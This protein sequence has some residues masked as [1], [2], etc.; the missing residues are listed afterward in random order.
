MV[1][2]ARSLLLAAVVAATP[3]TFAA[4]GDPDPAFG[5]GG[6]VAFN[7]GRSNDVMTATVLQPDG[8]VIAV[9]RSTA[10]QRSTLVLARYLA[11]GAADPTFGDAGLVRTD[12]EAGV[13]IT[14]GTALQ[15]DG[16]L[17]V[18]LGLCPS[19]ARC[20]ARFN[21]NGTLDPAFGTAGRAASGISTGSVASVAIQPDGKIVGTRGGVLAHGAFRVTASG[22]FDPS[23]GGDGIVDAAEPT[24][25]SGLLLQPDGR[26]VL[27]GSTQG[28]NPVFVAYRVNADG[29]T[30][31]SFSASIPGTGNAYASALQWDGR[32]VIAGCTWGSPLA[33]RVVRLLGSG[34]LDASL[35]GSGIATPQF[36]SGMGQPCARS[37]AIRP[38]GKIAIAGSLFLYSFG[39]MTVQLMPDG[40]PDASFGTNGLVSVTTGGTV[41]QAKALVLQPDGRLVVGGTHFQRDFALARVGPDGTHDTSFGPGGVARTEFWGGRSGIIRRV[42]SWGDKTVVFARLDEAPADFMIPLEGDAGIARFLADGSPDPSFGFRGQVTAS[43]NSVELLR[44]SQFGETRRMAVQPDGKVLIAGTGQVVLD[45]GTRVHQGAT[46]ARLN[47]D[48]SVDASFGTGGWSAVIEGPRGAEFGVLA[49]DL[50]PDGRILAAGRSFANGTAI[51]FLGRLTPSGALDSSFGTAGLVSIPIDGD[52]SN[53]GD[54]SIGLEPDGRILLSGFEPKRVSVRRFLANGS[55][56]PSFASGGAYEASSGI[57]KTARGVH[58]HSDGR[59]LLAGHT[60]NPQPP[61]PNCDPYVGMMARTNSAGIVDGATL[62]GG[63]MVASALRAFV[64]G[65]R[66][67][68]QDRLLMAGTLSF[69]CAPASAV[70]AR[71]TS[72]GARDMA[73]GRAG[74]VT[75]ADMPLAMTQ[76]TDLSVQPDSKLVVGGHRLG[77]NPLFGL[78]RLMGGDGSSPPPRIEDLDY[79]GI[80]NALEPT[81]GRD[82]TFKDNDIFGIETCCS[83]RHRLFVMQQ[84]RDFLGREGDAAGVGY[85]VNR[86]QPVS[87]GGASSPPITPAHVIDAFVGSPEFQGTLAPVA[88]LY[89]AY[90]RRAPDY[91]GV[92]YWLGRYRAGA[93]LQSISDAFAASAE[94]A[95]TYGALDNAGFVT[96]VYQNILGR[97]ADPDGLAYWKAQLDSNAM[98]RGGV[99]LQFS[100]SAEYVELIRN[101]VYVTMIYMGM[102]R[103]GPDEAGYSFWVGYM[104][105]GNPGQAL[106][107]GFLGSAEYRSRFLP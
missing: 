38:D 30:D 59:V 71:F 54:V 4:P 90:F 45:A 15:P 85:W 53:A 2:D 26:I 81:L 58:V 77:A 57:G 65:T 33:V 44:F 21:A 23:F 74:L 62:G 92:Q 14:D 93:T 82:P 9:G 91:D 72:A 32:I 49:L 34:A 35:A 95:S 25:S 12:I 22:A 11:N 27:T 97:A 101:H 80:P 96:L 29:S 104:D 60:V 10:R 106:I 103:R 94:F 79:D 99:M 3:V 48:G 56:D 16:K 102:L 19:N 89:L 86:L 43:I 31:P 75:V 78:V 55:P 66:L 68:A 100:E 17:V 73:F 64:W 7:L 28:S 87:S 8:K 42:A 39:L 36:Q 47:A 83:L 69:G 61:F 84:F 5:S 24:D 105:D 40:A 98:T 20:L 1:I 67:D 13:A 37:I 63:L 46:V 70:L 52:T 107:N 50:L 76:A 41:D 18:L 51:A 6:G 88:R